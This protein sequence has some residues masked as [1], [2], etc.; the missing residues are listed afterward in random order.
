MTQNDVIVQLLEWKDVHSILLRKR[1]Q[2]VDT[3]PEAHF[4]VLRNIKWLLTKMLMR[5]QLL[6]CYRIWGNFYFFV[7]FPNV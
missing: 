3:N 6:K 1:K 4:L 5:V 7:L 2:E